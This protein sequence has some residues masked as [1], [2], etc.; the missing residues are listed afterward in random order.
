MLWHQSGVNQNGEP[1]VQLL[2][3]DKPIAQMN[4]RE[5]RDY[6]RVITECSEAAET[7]AF[8]WEFVTKDLK[9]TQHAAAAMMVAFRRFREKRGKSVPSSDP[10]EFVRP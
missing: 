9:Q 6:A 1:F 4:P 7:N 3:N 10:S 5:A 2:L 8:L